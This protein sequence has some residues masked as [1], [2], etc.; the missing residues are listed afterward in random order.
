[1]PGGYRHTDG[2]GHIG[3]LGR[4]EHHAD[5]ALPQRLAG[6]PAAVEFFAAQRDEEIARPD[7]PAVGGD[8]QHLGILTR[9]RYAQ[10]G[11]GFGKTH[12]VH[13]SVRFAP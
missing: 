6:K 12:H 2:G 8:A 7:R 13:A 1:M 10:H 4:V 3:C 11:G 5:R 9:K